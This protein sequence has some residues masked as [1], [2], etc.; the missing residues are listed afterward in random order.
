MAQTEQAPLL[1]LIDDSPAIHRLMAFKLKNEGLEFITSYT[2]EEG[3]ELARTQQPALILLDLQ[4]PGMSG[5]DVLRALKNDPVTMN[6]PVIIVT[7]S[8]ESEQKVLA[9][10]LGALDVVSK[11][12][13]VHELRARIQSAIRI[14]RLMK[15]LEQRAQI[16]G[17]TGL[18]N[19]KYFN[20]RL[21]A[22]LDICKRK[23]CGLSLLI[24]DLDHFKKI[25]DTFGHPA[26]DA[27][28]QA[29]ASILNRELRSYDVACRYGGEEFA[30]ILPDSTFEQAHKVAER[31]RVE[32]AERRWPNYPDVRAAASFGVADTPSPDI[33]GIEAWIAAADRALYHSKQTGRNRITRFA[34]MPTSAASPPAAASDSIK[35]HRATAA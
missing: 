4:M 27:V 16:D 23:G 29:F 12:F 8:T 9:F 3:V 20:E 25:N 6:I 10:E 2:G 32:I 1:L 22:E 18:W 35:T 19:R 26:G 13:D 11:P 14:H 15:M 33:T 34:D 31:I 5:F 30:I 7:G 24:C 21:A 17:L 28:L